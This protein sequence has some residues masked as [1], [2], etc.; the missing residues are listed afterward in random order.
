MGQ[1]IDIKTKIHDRFSI[2]FK[3]G[4]LARSKD[5]NA[6]FNVGMWI[7]V[8]KSLDINAATYPKNDFYRDV[9]SNVRLITPKFLLRDMADPL[10]KVSA[11]CEAMASNASKDNIAEYEY[12][13]KMFAAIVK[14]ALRDETD[15]ILASDRD[16][17]YL[18]EQYCANIQKVIEEF[19]ALRNII[20]T[21][22]VPSE[23]METWQYCDE[24]ICNV[25][26]QHSFKLINFLEEQ[27]NGTYTAVI[28]ALKTFIRSI[29]AYRDEMGYSSVRESVSHNDRNYLY[30]HGVLKKFVESQLFLRVPKKRDGVVVEQLYYSIAAGLAMIFATVIAWAFQK[31]FGNLTWPLFI[32]LIISYMLKDR[33]KEL[34]RY[35]FAH[36]VGSK[37]FDNKAKIEL[38]GK[39]I[40]WLKE[41]VD[42]ISSKNL[43]DD[44][45]RLR[46]Q[47][48][49]LKAANRIDDDK[50]ILYRKSVHIDREKMSDGSSYNLDGINDIIRLHVNTFVQKMDNPIIPMHV[51]EPDDSV[52]LVDC[53]KDYYLNIVLQYEFDGAAD[54]KR[55]RITM[56]RDGIK[57]I[58]QIV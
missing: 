7:F 35:Y 36:K 8:P 10:A 57:N 13:I 49:L 3:V 44:I 37:Y 43:P 21:P 46:A 55:F 27:N 56:T 24:F 41:G 31:T 34:M 50:I 51:L 53:E 16:I 15:H 23:Q 33:I 1:Q 32:A 5:R 26:A 38:K 12:Q 2:E 47:Q 17:N 30:R 18:C 58:E 48:P 4:F 19:R 25:S 29:N 9:K 11:A 42:F 28:S 45:V 40:G 22:S 39:Q 20:N 54:Y 6:D 14:S 52:G